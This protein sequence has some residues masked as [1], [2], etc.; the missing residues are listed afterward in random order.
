MKNTDEIM[1]MG[2]LKKNNTIHEVLRAVLFAVRFLKGFFAA[3][4]TRMR[5]GDWDVNHG[6]SFAHLK[7]QHHGI[8]HTHTL[9]RHVVILEQ[10]RLQVFPHTNNRDSRK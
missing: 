8:A 9:L 10:R 7:H 3:R 2:T 4:D 6:M 5:R 1:F